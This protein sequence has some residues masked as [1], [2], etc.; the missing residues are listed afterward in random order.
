MIES[1]HNGFWRLFLI[2][3]ACPN[4][5]SV[6]VLSNH[7]FL[8]SRWFLETIFQDFGASK[9]FN[10]KSYFISSRPLHLAYGFHG[11]FLTLPHDNGLPKPFVSPLPGRVLPVTVV[12]YHTYSLQFSLLMPVSAKDGSYYA[13][14]V[15]HLFKLDV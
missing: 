13:R 14:F 7:S 4:Y 9:P 12:K 15:H 1:L 11:P 2:N 6:M 10:S 8:R 3:L 5:F